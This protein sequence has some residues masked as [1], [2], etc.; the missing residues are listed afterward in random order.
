MPIHLRNAPT[1]MMKN[2]AYG[3]DYRYAHNESDGYIAGE[4]YMPDGILEPT[5][6]RPV[7]RGLEIKIKEKLAYL[8]E[9]D[10]RAR[11]KK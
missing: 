9:L 5:W 8:K 3:K 10:R 1:Q 7:E 2:I 6:Y 4:S 11:Q